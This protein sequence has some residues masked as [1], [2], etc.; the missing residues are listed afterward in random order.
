MCPA[1]EVTVLRNGRLVA[2]VP[3]A[4]TTRAELAELMVG[5]EVLFTSRRTP[6]EPGDV[7]FAI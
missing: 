7:L 4:G 3:A 2:T 5:R 1:A 6:Q